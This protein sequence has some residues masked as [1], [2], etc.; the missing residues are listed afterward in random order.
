MNASNNDNSIPSQSKGKRKHATEEAL[1]AV[2][3][4][5]ESEAGSLSGELR[6]EIRE[7]RS[8]VLA[9]RRGLQKL[10]P[11]TSMDAFATASV[12]VGWCL[13]KP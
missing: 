2:K 12:Q 8:Q 3:E 5:L 7:S 9:L 4:A 10:E 13:L 1:A 6:A 11:E